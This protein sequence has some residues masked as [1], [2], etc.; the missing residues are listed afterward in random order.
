MPCKLPP[1]PGS[2]YTPYSP[3]RERGGQWPHR[4]QRP[5]P[6]GQFRELVAELNALADELQARVPAFN[7]PPSPRRGCCACCATT[8]TA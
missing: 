8:S 4:H 6:T 3:D 2:D 1:R 5:R 7:P